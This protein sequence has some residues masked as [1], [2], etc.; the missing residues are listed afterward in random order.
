MENV[1]DLPL[2]LERFT[3]T[4]KMEVGFELYRWPAGGSYKDALCDQR[5]LFHGNS[6]TGWLFPIL[7]RRYTEFSYRLV[8]DCHVMAQ[9]NTD[10]NSS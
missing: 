8:V 2:R 1:V 10:S 3:W 7:A 4:P 9:S 6:N 5:P